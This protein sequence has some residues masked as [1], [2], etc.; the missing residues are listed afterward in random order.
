MLKKKQYI[1]M[2]DWLRRREFT[3]KPDHFQF[4]TE[5]KKSKSGGMVPGS[6][7]VIKSFFFFFLRFA[8]AWW[9]E[10]GHASRFTFFFIQWEIENDLA[11]A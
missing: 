2:C 4:L 7:F 9:T 8:H 1:C 5:S 3:Q 10:A 11:F 6:D